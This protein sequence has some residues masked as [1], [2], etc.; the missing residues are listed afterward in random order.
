MST[1][2][3]YSSYVLPQAYTSA[4]ATPSATTTFSRAATSSASTLVSISASALALFNASTPVTVAKVVSDYDTGTKAFKTLTAPVAISDTAAN[5]TSAT[6]LVKLSGILNDNPGNLD[7]ISF[8]DSKAPTLKFSNAQSSTTT[9]ILSTYQPLLSK[10][11]SAYTL[12]VSDVS[13]ADFN[14]LT[15]TD[16]GTSATK[17]LTGLSDTLT[18]ILDNTT[19]QDLATMAAAK[20]LTSIKLSSAT[21]PANPTTLSVP[22][23]TSAQA[24]LKLLPTT[25]T[26]SLSVTNAAVADL[27]KLGGDSHVKSITVSDSASNLV[28]GLAGLK[29]LAGKSPSPLQTV[30]VSPST[31]VL[32]LTVA[33][34]TTNK[35]ML[36]S[37]AF[38]NVHIQISDTAANIA[39]AL[40]GLDSLAKTVATNGATLDHVTATD[41]NVIAV[42]ASD[43]LNDVANEA[44]LFQGNT[45]KLT[46]APISRLADIKAVTDP[47]ITIA[48]VDVSDTAANLS[49]DLKAGQAGQISTALAANITMNSITISD[50]KALSLSADDVNNNADILGLV[51]GN[52]A[53]A[54][55]PDLSVADGLALQPPSANAKLSFG[56]TD[57]GTNVSNNLDDIQALVKAGT[58]TSL[59]LTAPATVTLTPAQYKADADAL[60]LLKGTYDLVLT[61]AMMSDL[62]GLTTMPHVSKISVTDTSAA[63]AKNLNTLVSLAKSNKLGTVN[64]SDSMP[65]PVTPKQYTALMPSM[66]ANQAGDALFSAVSFKITNATV[67]DLTTLMGQ[68]SLP[69]NIDSIDVQDSSANISNALTSLNPISGMINKITLTDKK[70][71]LTMPSTDL[72]AYSDLLGLVQ[73]G[74]KLNLSDPLSVDKATSLTAP[75]ANATLA[76][77]VSDTQANIQDNIDALQVLVKSKQLTS[78]QISDT[79]KPFVIS[80]ASLKSDVDAINLLKPPS[81]NISDVTVADAMSLPPVI[82]SFKLSGNPPFTFAIN[83][84]AKN[85]AAGWSSLDSLYKNNMVS[86]ISVSDGAPISLSFASAKKSLIL[87]FDSTKQTAVNFHD[88]VSL[89][90][91]GLKASD[92]GTNNTDKGTALYLAKKLADTNKTL[93]DNN[94]A[95]ATI[96]GAEISDTAGNI[97]KNLDSLSKAKNSDGS[98]VASKITVTDK[99]PMTLTTNNMTNSDITD[100]LALISNAYSIK[101]DP[102]VKISVSK[103]LALAAPNKNA[104]IM[105]YAVTDTPDN[106]VASLADILKLASAK[107]ISQFTLTPNTDTMVNFTVTKDQLSKAAPILALIK[108]SYGVNLT[109]LSAS[110]AVASAKTAK[111]QSMALKDSV[112]NLTAS[113]KAL[114][115]LSKVK[116]IVVTDA[117]PD[118][119]KLAALKTALPNATF[120]DST[121]KSI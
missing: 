86:D 91:T 63:I 110:D 43:F 3:G 33:Q 75:S 10:V 70:P 37:A 29:T 101:M 78:L 117:K 62:A 92:I 46:N 71:A 72:D 84:T 42:S 58:V 112:A 114:Q 14:N 39:G 36:S 74:F 121:G 38:K 109:G 52:Y 99:S 45:V 8:T 12:S 120:T 59:T 116:T 83:D 87:N 66:Q 51:S 22:E 105:P 90:L 44:V 111:L 47:L 68:G 77:T 20:T 15:S 55:S 26:Y 53:I 119:T 107:S 35:D 18:N 49:Q 17:Q 103:A 6:N 28:A 31:D 4:T 57:T 23:Y 104:T 25:A 16:Y 80:A 40:S 113:L 64:P 65:I 81:L 19:L 1:I 94:Q 85:I 5:I 108:G 97:A 118:A 88:G 34:A 115:A 95:F 61:D 56:V 106:L 41:G 48:S 11:Q 67:N 32:T 30:T 82:K 100:V 102:S 50:N 89:V 7:T 96:S 24:A 60:K 73:N 27:A 76:F 79:P 13:Y 69:Q 54:V 9:P 98:L 93:I 21:A 2:T